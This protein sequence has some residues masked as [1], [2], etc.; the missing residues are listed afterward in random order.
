M[1]DK[2]PNSSEK[3][4]GII[5]DRKL[6]E[7]INADPTGRLI[8]VD[9]L[10]GLTIVFMAFFHNFQFFTGNL[11]SYANAVGDSPIALVIEFLG[12]WAGLFYIIS[13]FTHGYSSYKQFAIKKFSPKKYIKYSVISG[14]WLIFLSKFFGFF[15]SRTSVGGGIYGFNQ[16]PPHYSIFGSLLETGLV[17][18]PDAYTMF[19]AMSALQLIGYSIIINSIIISLLYRNNGFKKKERNL[20]VFLGIGIFWILIS[21]S[22]IPVLRP[23][24]VDALKSNKVFLTLITGV[25]VADTQPLLPFFGYFILGVFFGTAFVMK[26]NRKMML[27]LGLMLGS[28]FTAIGIIGYAIYGNPPLNNIIQTLTQREIDLQIGLMI[29]LLIAVYAWESSY[30]AGSSPKVGKN[31]N[32]NRFRVLQLFGR[33]SLTVFLMEG[34]LATVIKVSI[35]NWLIPSWSNYMYAIVIFSFSQIA[36]WSLLLSYWKSKK[37]K[38][39]I[40]W[41]T[42]TII[43]KKK[44]V[45]S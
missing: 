44:V 25:L 40:E 29:Y 42:N 6:D 39:S 20:F 41:F 33:F 31:R 9:A 3:L 27:T 13:G 21:G 43:K 5:P 38:F 19:F 18:L 1:D 45:T 30:I 37:M 14:V 32:L 34:F 12:R 17:H 16:G 36:I 15:F 10:R 26:V 24:W 28:L 2:E 35:L 7:K 11:T 8:G 23:I 4:T 22:C